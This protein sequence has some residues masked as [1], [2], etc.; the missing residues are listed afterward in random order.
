MALH[1]S[2]LTAGL[3]SFDR[4]R[5]AV[6]STDA[7]ECPRWFDCSGNETYSCATLVT[8]LLSPAEDREIKSAY[9]KLALIES[10]TAGTRSRRF[11]QIY[12]EGATAY[13]ELLCFLGHATIYSD[14][15]RIEQS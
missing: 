8:H 13:L 2:S 14:L 10:F 7:A 1:G 3:R 6:T 4:F 5:G 12:S 11:T 15:D 9:R